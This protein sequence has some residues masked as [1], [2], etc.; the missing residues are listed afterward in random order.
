M[1]TV[2]LTL[3]AW[4]SIPFPIPFT[5]Q[6]FGIYTAL[7]LAGGKQGLLSLLLYILLGA[8]GLPVFSGFSSG[9]G[10]LVSPTGGYI[11]GFVMCALLYLLT[12]KRTRKN[13]CM[14]FLILSVG[15]LLC[16]ISGTLWFMFSF[17]NFHTLWQTLVLCVLPYII[18][19]IIKMIIAVFLTDKIKPVLRKNIKE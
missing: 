4:I 16:Y 9:V 18:P 10:H 3:C 14:K 12:E 6:T 13:R 19:D 5:L 17:G 8:A 11:W 2:L 1:V 15:T 7:L